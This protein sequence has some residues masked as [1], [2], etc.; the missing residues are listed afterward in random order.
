MNNKQ[1]T[2]ALSEYHKVTRYIETLREA[3]QSLLARLGKSTQ[4]DNIE[5][6]I[7]AYEDM[8]KTL[9]RIIEAGWEA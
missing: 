1:A 3:R 2:L 8:A 5:G 7:T 9:R 6:Q 4:I